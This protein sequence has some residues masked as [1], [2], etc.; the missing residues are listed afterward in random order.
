MT[1]QIASAMLALAFAAALIVAGQLYI[2]KSSTSSGR[3]IA[4][5][6]NCPRAK[7]ILFMRKPWNSLDLLRGANE[8]CRR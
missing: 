5:T 3:V 1:D 6:F 7:V 2:E 4:A 8:A